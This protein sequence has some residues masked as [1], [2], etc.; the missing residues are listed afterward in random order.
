MEISDN[1]TKLLA[2][3]RFCGNPLQRFELRETR[4][5]NRFR[6]SQPHLDYKLKLCLTGCGWWLMLIYYERKILLAGWCWFDVREKYCWLDAVNRVGVVS[7]YCNWLQPASGSLGP[8]HYHTCVFQAL[9]RALFPRTCLPW[10]R[11]MIPRR[12]FQRATAAQDH[13]TR[14]WRRMNP[15][16]VRVT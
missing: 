14:A 8:A 16:Q 5:E 15:V 7:G 6:F 13:M 1:P 10:H 4:N 3:F 2:Y 12:R 11:T 9:S